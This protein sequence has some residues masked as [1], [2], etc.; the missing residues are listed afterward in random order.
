MLTQTRPLHSTTV[1]IDR[2]PNGYGVLLAG[3]LIGSFED[4]PVWGLSG[5]QYDTA[6][7]L[8]LED[9]DD[10]YVYG[11]RVFITQAQTIAH[12]VANHLAATATWVMPDYA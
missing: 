10:C 9:V 8:G 7:A 12:I 2:H 4:Y 6:R 3:N 1:T 11:D 5:V